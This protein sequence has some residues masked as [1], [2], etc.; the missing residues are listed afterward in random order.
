MSNSTPIY[1]VKL[2][3]TSWDNSFPFGPTRNH[4]SHLGPYCDLSGVTWD[5]LCYFWAYSNYVAPIPAISPY[6]ASILVKKVTTLIMGDDYIDNVTRCLTQPLCTM[7]SLLWHLEINFSLLGLLG[8]SAA[9]LGP[10]AT[11]L[12]FPGPRLPILGLIWPM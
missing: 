2:T 9:P 7:L 3:L 11:F 10:I 6:P 12:G 8:N 4:C 1:H 5:S